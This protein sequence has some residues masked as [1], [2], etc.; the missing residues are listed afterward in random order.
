MLW[1]F[2]KLETTAGK[3]IC[4]KWA[5]G[6]DSISFAIVG[7]VETLLEQWAC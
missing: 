3:D 4:F 5:L 7:Q 1:F 2:L 6:D